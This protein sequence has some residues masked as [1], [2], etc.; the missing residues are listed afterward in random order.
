MAGSNEQTAPSGRVKIISLEAENTKRIKAFSA[1][2]E[3]GLNIIGGDN[4]EGKSTV[5]HIIE[6]LCKGG[7]AKPSNP[8]R[9]GSV[10]DPHA[11]LVLSN[12]FKIK[13]SGKNNTLKVT[14]P[15]GRSIGQKAMQD[16]FLSE[17]A[18]DIPK[19][20]TASE[21]EKVKMLLKAKGVDQALAD[22]ELKEAKKYNERTVIGQQADEKRK[23][24]DALNYDDSVGTEKHS[25]QALIE[26]QQ[27]IL[28]RNAENAKARNEYAAN[29]QLLAQKEQQ[30]QYIQNQIHQLQRQ[31][32]SVDGEVLQFARFDCCWRKRC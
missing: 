22:L 10:L 12:G 24:A 32:E 25:A 29:R 28:M 9:E 15:S 31:L 17:F 20:M 14:D 5:L 7:K 3:D 8:K 13:L 18:L 27:A 6:W 4:G 30:L 11:E 21:T 23:Y 19:F 16:A 2:F 1:V 26:S